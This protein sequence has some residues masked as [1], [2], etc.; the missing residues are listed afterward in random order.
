MGGAAQV[1]FTQTEVR[2]QTPGGGYD[3]VGALGQTLY[4]LVVTGTIVAAIDGD[5]LYS[6]VVGEA[7][8]GLVNL[9]GQFAGGGHDEAVDRIVGVRLGHEQVD[10]GQEICG[11]LSGAG[12]RDTYQVLL[13]ENVGDALLLHGRAFVEV[14]VVEGIEKVVAEGEVFKV[15]NIYMVVCSAFGISFLLLLRRALVE[16]E[17]DDGEHDVGNPYGQGGR[18]AGIRREGGRHRLEHDVAETER[19]TGTQRHAHAAFPLLRGQRHAYEREDEGGEG[20]GES[21]VV[22]HLEGIDA[23]HAAQFLLVDKFGQFGQRQRLLLI[24]D[25]EEVG[26]LHHD[27]GVERGVCAD[28][29]AHAFEGA[30]ADVPQRPTVAAVSQ[31]V[32]LDALRRQVRHEFAVFKFVERE[33]VAALGLVVEAGDVGHDARVGLH[34]DVV[35]LCDGLLLDIGVL[36]VDTCHVAAGDDVGA[37]D[38]GRYGD[39]GCGK[40]V[41]PQQPPET[42]AGGFHGDNLRTRCQFGGEEDDGYEN[43]ERTEQV[44]KV[45]DEVQEVVENDLIGRDVALGKLVNLLVIVEDDGD[46]YDDGY[47]EDVGGK[48]LLDD[49]PIQFLGHNVVFQL[50]YQACH[51]LNGRRAA[52][53]GVCSHGH[54]VRFF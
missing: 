15:H 30:D 5:A 52:G 7:L 10:D 2:N 19:Q 45:G 47:Q 17:G 18:E 8:Q 28:F 51:A 21:F 44:D 9:P 42:H 35:G 53:C 48:K 46:E 33:A 4:L 32:V 25:I 6:G 38:E 3:D 37:E 36:K 34:L 12:L 13:F 29:L 39:E 22:F 14:H 20:G 41:G 54:K 40:H 49:I 27:D 50:S 43:E 11:G 31:R 1:Q 23:L 16:H 26:G 24:L